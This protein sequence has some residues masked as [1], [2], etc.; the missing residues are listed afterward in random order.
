MRVG[1]NLFTVSR[2]GYYMMRVFDVDT[3]IT[4]AHYTLW[5]ILYPLA[6]LC[7]GEMTICERS[8]DL[9]STVSVVLFRYTYAG[10][11]STFRTVAEAVHPSA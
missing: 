7:E 2:H 9:M 5:F 1:A 8:I 10:Q 11:H 6:F 4:W 3:V